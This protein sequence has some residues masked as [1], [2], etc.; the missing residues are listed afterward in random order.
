MDEDRS[1][2]GG[3]PAKDDDDDGSYYGDD[4]DRRVRHR[5]GRLR[6][7]T[8]LRLRTIATQNGYESER[9]RLGTE[10]AS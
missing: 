2:S 9:L 3:A 1:C 10:I 8:G 7:G 4:D 5:T 6:V